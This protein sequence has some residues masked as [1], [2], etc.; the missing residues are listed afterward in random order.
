VIFTGK[1][2]KSR[3]PRGS[4]FDTHAHT[5]ESTVT[6]TRANRHRNGFVKH[7]HW[8]VLSLY[9]FVVGR[10]TGRDKLVYMT[11]DWHFIHKMLVDLD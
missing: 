10:A 1:R 3:V 7:T 5:T 9:T 8:K 11:A 2:L 6:S 4:A